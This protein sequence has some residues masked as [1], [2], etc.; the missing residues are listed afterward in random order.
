MIL[1][2]AKK[3]YES[4]IEGE[5]T[6]IDEKKLISL[7]CL[8]FGAGSRY[9]KEV[10]KDLQNAG[11]LTIQNKKIYYIPQGVTENV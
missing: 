4:A 2:T 3:F 8:E 10:I 5:E 1:A 11:Y 7:V 6:G 9:V